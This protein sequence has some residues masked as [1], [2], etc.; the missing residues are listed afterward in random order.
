MKYKTYRDILKENLKERTSELDESL[1]PLLEKTAFD[2][3][4]EG[5]VE[6][7]TELNIRIKQIT[8]A[9]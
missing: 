1:I 3:M 2:F 4:N 7:Q 5:L 9:A 6:V 8:E